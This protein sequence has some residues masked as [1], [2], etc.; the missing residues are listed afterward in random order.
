ML[1]FVGPVILS[2]LVTF[3]SSHSNNSTDPEISW[4]GYVY[5]STLV[6]GVILSS[7]VGSQYTYRVRRISMRVRSAIVSL[8]Y[9]KALSIS[10]L[11]KREFSS[12]Q[13]TNIMSVDTERIMDIC[14]S[15][16]NLWSLPVQIAGNDKQHTADRIGN[17]CLS[18]PDF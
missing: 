10:G 11:S 5:A 13:V 9:S 16:H 15:F 17:S 18:C 7:I 14:L 4:H 3:L 12:G 2:D 1:L 6:S 8:V